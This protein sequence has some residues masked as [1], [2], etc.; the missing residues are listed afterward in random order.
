MRKASLVAYRVRAVTP[1]ESERTRFWRR[2]VVSK[3][4]I[5]RG[6]L[7]L[8]VGYAVFAEQARANRGACPL[9]RYFLA[10]YT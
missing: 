5:K 3:G 8:D 7:M 1:C 10:G 9:T 6:K 2:A 4:I